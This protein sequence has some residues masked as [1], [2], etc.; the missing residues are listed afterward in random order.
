MMKKRI[1]ETPVINLD[2]NDNPNAQYVYG[3]CVLASNQ[4]NGKNNKIIIFTDRKK[5][6]RQTTGWDGDG[7]IYFGETKDKRL[8]ENRTPFSNP[9]LVKMKVELG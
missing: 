3:W 8:Y 1:N 2:N 7:Y 4:E 6:Q 5:P 9:I